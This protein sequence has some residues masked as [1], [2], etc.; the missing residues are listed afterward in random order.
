MIRAEFSVSE[1]SVTGFTLKG[2]AGLASS[3]SDVLCAAVSAMALLTVNLL[4]EIFGARFD[5]TENEEKG[6]LSLQLSEVPAGNKNAV[7]GVLQGFMLQLT[8]L[9]D[10]YHDNLSVTI[11][12]R[13]GR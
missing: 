10:Q 4:K 11:K 2:H 6:F 9:R 8:D 13:N 12:E 7:K 3:G 5:L 1:Q